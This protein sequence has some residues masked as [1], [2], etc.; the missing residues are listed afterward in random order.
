[1]AGTDQNIPVRSGGRTTSVSLGYTF[2]DDGATM[3]KVTFKA[4]AWIMDHRDVLPADNEAISSPPKVS[5]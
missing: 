2:T 3:G 4:T 1:M 5:R